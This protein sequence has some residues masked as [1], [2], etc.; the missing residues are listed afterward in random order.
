[1]RFK[2]TLFLLV[3][4]I[5]TFGL[6][7]H[8]SGKT[9][10]AGN[11]SRSLFSA[12]ISKISVAGNNLGD[13][14]LLELRK[15][16]WFIA[17][18]YSW[19]ANPFVVNPLLNDLRF[20]GD[21]GSFSVEEA[22]VAGSSLADYGL[23]NPALTLDV[24]DDAGTHTLKIGKETPDARGVY[25]LSP[26]GKQIILAKTSLLKSLSQKLD[27]FRSPEIFSMAS[28]EVRSFSVRLQAKSG[29]EQRIGLTRTRREIGSETGKSEY[30]WRFETPVTGDAETQKV[31]QSLK[32][33]T[34]L[35][36]KQFLVGDLALLEASGLSSPALRFSFYG[37]M[38]SQTLLV[39][40]ANPADKTELYAKLDGNDAIFTIA[41]DAVDSWKNI[42]SA[43]ADLR[44]P[45][46][47]K[48]E[49]E[50]LKSI[51]IHTEK[52]S[53]LLHRTNASSD[54][55]EAPK[56]VDTGSVELEPA[57]GKGPLLGAVEQPVPAVPATGD[58]IY[59]AWQMPVAPGSRVTSVTAVDPAAIKSLVE[60]LR[61]LRA[62]NM[63]PPANRQLSSGQRKFFQAFVTDD[64]S[65]SDLREL[66]FNNPI[67]IVELEL[68]ASAKNSVPAQTI[69]LTIAAPIEPGFPYHAKV[70]NAVY[71]IDKNVVDLLSIE[72][73]YFRERTIYH[74]PASAKLVSM[75]LTDISASPEKTAYKEQC[76]PN[77]A[78]WMAALSLKTDSESSE[79]LALARCV[80]HLDAEAFLP[81]AFSPDFKYD[82]LDSGVPE[83]WRWKLEIEILPA[84][85]QKPELHVY[86]LTKRLGGT[87]QLAG[88]PNQ[89]CVFRMKQSFIDAIH[90]LTF[91]RDFSNDIP[92]IPIPPPVENEPVSTVPADKQ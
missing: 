10:I 86:Y 60:T 63:N 75:K 53:L 80:T 44:E 28:Y 41:A 79:T 47:L 4:N 77:V 58:E 90:K 84:T 91:A 57:S 17:K 5:L 56:S 19:P 76:P 89:N 65:E 20:L 52:N 27:N 36:Y 51:T 34:S 11:I 48:F 23:E 12:G 40:N 16:D 7:L 69:T 21:E 32:I 67:R 74:L 38:R 33:L 83:T 92:E 81:T 70:G 30:G 50:L 39:G 25:V 35:K 2:L 8:E 59:A 24:T 29:H 73:S 14:F 85:A 9:E 46:F 78:D 18:P 45:R 37:A 68:N 6:I 87:F 71:T 64:A 13:G 72:P 3:A 15:K 82:Y 49:P 42:T 88:S 26:D 62:I 22:Q 43:V 61:N 66:G 54:G 1:M 31:E 55:S